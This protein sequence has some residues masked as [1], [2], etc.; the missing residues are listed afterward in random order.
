M[1]IVLNTTEIALIIKARKT[2]KPY[3]QIL[4]SLACADMLTGVL[5]TVFKI[6]LLFNTSDNAAN[7]E[8]NILSCMVL[9]TVMISIA[10][11]VSI[12]IDRLMAVKYPL[13]HRVYVTKTRVWV[14]AIA[15]WVFTFLLVTIPIALGKFGVIQTDSMSLVYSK[16]SVS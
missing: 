7:I 8:A 16:V 6:Y 1:T 11:L 3:V 9:S 4:S 13:I 12:T 5:L 10:T 15:E 14:C 2:I